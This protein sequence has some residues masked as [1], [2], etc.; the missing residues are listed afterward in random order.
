MSRKKV[1][2]DF[3]AY[4]ASSQSLLDSVEKVQDDANVFRVTA[5]DIWG[6]GRQWN[7]RDF[8]HHIADELLT[9]SKEAFRNSM[10][11]VPQTINTF[12]LQPS[13]KKEF[14]G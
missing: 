8:V 10:N 3:R 7:R 5:T 11:S 4:S 12:E 6:N 13:D 14:C 9:S 2:V 1:K